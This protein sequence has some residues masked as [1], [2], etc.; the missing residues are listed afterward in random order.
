[1]DGAIRPRAS[2]SVTAL[3]ATAATI[4]ARG[5]ARRCHI[6]FGR[7]MRLVRRSLGGHAVSPYPRHI[8]WPVSI[9]ERVYLINCCR[10]AGVAYLRTLFHLRWDFRIIQTARPFWIEAGDVGHV[11]VL[12]VPIV[13]DD[14]ASKRIQPLLLVISRLTAR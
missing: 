11:V 3:T 10:P 14:S 12:H 8:P 5:P 13:F 6:Q 9:F 1:M 4:F 7:S 2:R